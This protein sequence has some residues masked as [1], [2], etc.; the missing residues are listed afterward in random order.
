MKMKHLKTR[1]EL[2]ESSENLN[3]SDVSGG[4]INDSWR[5]IDMEELYDY[6]NK[7]KDEKTFIKPKFPTRRWGQVYTKTSTTDVRQIDIVLG[8]LR[9]EGFEVRKKLEKENHINLK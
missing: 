3:I 2:N 4:L 9:D 5:V 8:K 1:Q 6:I 7:D